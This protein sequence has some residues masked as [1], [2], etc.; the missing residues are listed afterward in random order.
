RVYDRW[1]EL[2]FEGTG[3]SI[4]DASTGWDGTFK[5]KPMNSGLYAWY[6]EVEFADGH[7]EVIK[8]DI[9]LLR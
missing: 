3:L 5:G 7:V 9:T 8:G 6:A 1:G 4:N 2:I